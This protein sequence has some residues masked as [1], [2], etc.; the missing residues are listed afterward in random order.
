MGRRRRRRAG[1]GV[2]RTSDSHGLAEL[3][4]Q[5]E[6]FGKELVVIGEVVAEER[7]RLDERAAPGHDLRASAREQVESGELLEYSHR[8][9][10]AE[11]RDGAGDSD[12]LG[13]HGRGSKYD[14]RRRY[15]EVGTVVLAD[16]EH[17]EPHLLCEP[18]LL[19]QIAHPLLG[20]DR[21][22]GLRIGAQLRERVDAELHPAQSA[23]ASGA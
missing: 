11:D 1:R 23:S 12:S 10:G 20:A 16:A 22:T 18:D 15:E 14:R 9:V 13:A 17:V 5:L 19:Q 7:E 4:E 8:V 21:L 3:K 6:L 2:C